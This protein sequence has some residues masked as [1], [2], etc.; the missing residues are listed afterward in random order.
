MVGVAVVE[1]AGKQA[2]AGIGDAQCAVHEYFQFDVGAFL[3][4]FGDF[5]HAQFARQDDAFHADV[6]P[7]FH[8]PI[9][10]GVGL[11]GQVHGHVGVFVAHFHNQAGV[12]H[13]ECVGFH[14]D[15]GLH[16][17][18][19]G[20]ELAVVWQGVHGEVEFFAARVG[21]AD[22]LLQHVQF[23]KFVVAGAQGVARAAGIHGIGAEIEGGLHAF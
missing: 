22:A 14:G 21:F 17:G 15:E 4:D 5:V 7:E 11:H 10:G 8:A 13:D 12:G 16:V 18:V 6:L 1:V 20:F 3:A 2:A 23:G 9:V 19:E